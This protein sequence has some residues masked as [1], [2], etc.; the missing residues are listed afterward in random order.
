[1]EKNE[2][3]RTDKQVHKH[4]IK[5]Q[6]LRNTN[7]TKKKEVELYALILIYSLFKIKL[8]VLKTVKEDI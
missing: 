4:Y 8:F 2:E 6:I 3:R 1:M 5:T 7:L